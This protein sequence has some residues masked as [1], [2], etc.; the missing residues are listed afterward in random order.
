MPLSVS[1]VG[2][3]YVLEVYHRI[4]PYIRSVNI[5]SEQCAL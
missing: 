4:R 1:N 2:A 5:E 3:S